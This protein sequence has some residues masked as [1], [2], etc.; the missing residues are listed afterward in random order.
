[1]LYI[2]Y[3]CMFTYDNDVSSSF[4]YDDPM[5]LSMSDFI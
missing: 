3:M 5:F 1:M 2:G 4:A